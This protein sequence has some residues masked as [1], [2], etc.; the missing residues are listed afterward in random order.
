M[1]QRSQSRIQFIVGICLCLMLA[2]DGD[3][4][5]PAV[6]Q[7]TPTQE[8][9]AT[10]HASGTFDVKLTPQ[11]AEDGADAGWGRMSIDKQFHGDLEGSSKGYMLSSAATVV[12]GSGG[13]V[14]MERVTGTLKGRAGGFVLQ[15]S[16]TLTRG[17][18]QLSVT[19]VPDSGTGQLAGISGTFTIKI[20]GGKHSYD[21]EYTMPEMP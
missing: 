19:V 16:G 18:P 4:Q 13:Y 6:A 17:T 10:S 7:A 1:Q 21:F 20:D 3:A 12:K 11:A 5:N 2:A 15:H 9:V 14:A 8:K